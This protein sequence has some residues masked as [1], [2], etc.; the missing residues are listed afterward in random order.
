MKKLKGVLKNLP[1]LIIVAM[2]LLWLKTVVIGFIDFN[3]SITNPLQLLILLINPLPIIFLVTGLILLRS[4]NRQPVYMLLFM[5]I[6]SFILYAN[7]VYYREFTDFITIPLLT[8]GSNAAD[9]SASIVELVAWRDMIY[10]F[11]FMVMSV[12]IL[13]FAWKKKVIARKYHFPELKPFF[14]LIMVTFVVNIGLANIERPQ[15]LTR[16]F[17]RELIVKNIGIYSFHI[18]DTYLHTSTRV[19]R[20]FASAEELE[21][22]KEFVEEGLTEPNRDLFGIASGKN[23]ILIS[24]E[25][26]QNFVINNTVNGEEITP[27]L[28]ELIKD[29]IYFEEFY[30]QTAQGKTSDSEFLINTSLFPLSRGAVFFTHPNNE[31]YALPEILGENGYFTASLHA[32]NGTFWNRNVVYEQLGYD[33]F[34]DIEDYEVTDE[35]GWGMKDIDFMEQSI[36]HMTEM[37]APFYTK[38]ITLTNHF[39]FELDEEDHFI[40]PYDSNSRTVNRYFPTVRYT[41]EAIKVFFDR[42]KETGLY[43]E[44]IM[45]IY[46]DHYGISSFHKRAMSQYLEK[47]ITPFVE[48]QLQ[49][50]PLII[51]IPGL[52]GETISKIGGQIDLRP[53]LLHL[54]GIEV[55][56]QTT[57]GNDLFSDDREELVIFRNGNFIT[58]KVI[59]T[60]GTCYLKETGEPQV[61]EEGEESLCAPRLEEVERQLS[62]SDQIIYGDLLRFQ[63]R[64]GN[65]EEEIQQGPRR[66][67]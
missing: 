46:G 37:E 4:A 55:E 50:V 11:D 25:S 22:I 56:N 44:S 27:F 58:D 51:H 59:Y 49:Q 61:L 30:H 13:F 40:E 7:G 23:V 14:V 2:V 31:Y 35:V 65:G 36:E 60:G 3:I 41:D 29:S 64:E 28:N 45:I 34:Y 39:P 67:R 57:F 18:Y 19:Q 10:L 53:T 17:D 32:N 38:L 26:V 42:L 1:P 20:V 47:E 54:L 15:L 33:R 9:L 24:A 21:E 62:Y 52:E 63:K 6:T 12:L 43:E 5:L 66:K 16:S 48:V 8:V